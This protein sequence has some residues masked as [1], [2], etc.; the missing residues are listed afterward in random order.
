M[1]V[2]EDEFGF[3]RAGDA[4]SSS[5]F[6]VVIV[7]ATC[8]ARRTS[9][10]AGELPEPGRSISSRRRLGCS[11]CSTCRRRAE[12][13]F[14]KVEVGDQ[15]QRGPRSP[16][17]PSHETGELAVAGRP[18]RD[19][20]KLKVLS[21]ATTGGGPVPLRE[22]RVRFVNYVLTTGVRSIQV[23]L[24]RCSSRC[25][26]PS[27]RARA[28]NSLI[29]GS[30]GDRTLAQPSARPPSPLHSGGHW[31]RFEYVEPPLVRQALQGDAAALS[32]SEA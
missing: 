31:L 22:L 17:R 27:R 24:F 9:A 23:K 15:D 3:L 4:I 16:L 18:R 26:A 1:R 12:T 5:T 10:V 21:K 2:S 29:T 8:R 7:L 28:Q 20:A 6:S 14:R 25:P 30:P 11:F 19:F 13:R 32:E